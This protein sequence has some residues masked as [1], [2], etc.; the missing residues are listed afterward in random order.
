MVIAVTLRCVRRA[1]GEQMED[2]QLVC[3]VVLPDFEPPTA[4]L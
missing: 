4:D 3:Q 2:D 1:K